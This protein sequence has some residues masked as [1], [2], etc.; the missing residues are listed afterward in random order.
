M[1]LEL[2]KKSDRYE[3]LYGWKKFLEKLRRLKSHTKAWEIKKKEA[4][5]SELAGITVKVIKIHEEMLM[6]PPDHAVF[7]TLDR[8]EKRKLEILKIEEVMWKL[9]N[10]T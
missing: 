7:N 6:S 10:K 5:R 2:W 1:V 8:L 9:K 3:G 4:L